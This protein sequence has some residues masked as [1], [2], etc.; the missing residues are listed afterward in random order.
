MSSTIPNDGW[1]KELYYDR[2]RDGTLP[3]NIAVM[4]FDLNDSWQSQQDI[5]A[6][7]TNPRVVDAALPVQQLEL[8]R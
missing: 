3:P 2:W 1:A 5:E 7:K 6:L 8:L 4:E